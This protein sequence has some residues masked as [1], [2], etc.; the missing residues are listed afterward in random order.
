MLHDAALGGTLRHIN[1]RTPH[2]EAWQVAL[3]HPGPVAGPCLGL[4]RHLH[5]PAVPM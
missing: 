5:M 2:T 4:L 3:T 1:A